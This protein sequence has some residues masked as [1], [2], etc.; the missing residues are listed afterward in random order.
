MMSLSVYK[1]P[2]IDLDFKPKPNPYI[3][4]KIWPSL[5]AAVDRLQYMSDKCMFN[6]QGERIAKEQFEKFM[7]Q[8]LNH[9]DE[10]LKRIVYFGIDRDTVKF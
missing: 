1:Q 3:K 8:A 9:T 5:L 10:D 4:I 7:V 2:T 6:Q